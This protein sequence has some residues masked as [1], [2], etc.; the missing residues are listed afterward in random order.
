M[1]GELERVARGRLDEAEDRLVEELLARNRQRVDERVIRMQQAPLGID[2]GD[3]VRRPLEEVAETLVAL[4]EICLQQLHAVFQRAASIA[5]GQEVGD[6]HGQE[7][8]H[9]G[10]YGRRLA[11]RAVD[12]RQCAERR[13][14]AVGDRRRGDEAKERLAGDERVARQLPVRR[15]IVHHPRAVAHDRGRE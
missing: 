3:E 5:D 13:T 9:L 10:H 6:T 12:D 15:R 4:L 14:I 11:R 1:E 2:A 7:P 8:Q